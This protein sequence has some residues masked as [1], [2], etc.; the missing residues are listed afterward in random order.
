MRQ[1]KRRWNVEIFSRQQGPLMERIQ[2]LQRIGGQYSCIRRQSY[3]F[4]GN[5]LELETEY[6]DVGT[7]KDISTLY[8]GLE[9]LGQE[10]ED[11]NRGLPHGDINVKNVIWSG[12]EF[13]L[14]DWEPLL[15]IDLGDVVLLR[16]TRPYISVRDRLRSSLTK[17]TDKLGFFYFCRKTIHGWF[18]TVES[19]VIRFDDQIWRLDFPSVLKMAAQCP[20]SQGVSN[21]GVRDGKRFR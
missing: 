5:A 7:L 19:E 13:V 4:T 10:L 20:P 11:I 1:R 21:H 2:R 3:Q 17:D 14:I 16:G 18:P 15:E 8:R 12:Q 6:V 9:L